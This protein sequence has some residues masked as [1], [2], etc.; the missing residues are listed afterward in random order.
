MGIKYDWQ[1]PYWYNIIPAYRVTDL[2]ELAREGWKAGPMI[3]TPT[4]II[5]SLKDRLVRYQGSKQFYQSLSGLADE[6]KK[7]ILFSNGH[8]NLTVD[9]NPRKNEVFE[10]ISDFVHK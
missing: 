1:R 5:Q 10:W 9:L 3:K 2:V 4:L 7:L 8:H 6:A